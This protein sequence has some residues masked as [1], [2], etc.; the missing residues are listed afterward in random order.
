[1]SHFGACLDQIQGVSIIRSLKELYWWSERGR[2]GVVRTQS[3]IYDGAF[4]RKSLT[5]FSRYFPKNA[6]S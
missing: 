2:Q 5:A 4:L 3:N 6:L 1:M